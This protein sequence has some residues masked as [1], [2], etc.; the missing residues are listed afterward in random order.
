MVVVFNPSQKI[1]ANQMPKYVEKNGDTKSRWADQTLDFWIWRL[2]VTL[3]LQSFKMISA[4]QIH[5]TEN[6]DKEIQSCCD[7]V[8]QIIHIVPL[9]KCLLTAHKYQKVF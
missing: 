6:G 4:N 5:I 7:E 2:I 1:S 9:T 8:N 3:H